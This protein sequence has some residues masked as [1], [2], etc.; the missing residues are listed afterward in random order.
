VVHVLK[1]FDLIF[2]FTPF[3]NLDKVGMLYVVAY[4]TSHDPLAQHNSQFG[5]KQLGNTSLEKR[6][7]VLIWGTMRSCRSPDK[8]IKDVFVS[9]VPS[10]NQEYMYTCKCSLSSSLKHSVSKTRLSH[11]IILLCKLSSMLIH[12]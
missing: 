3:D 12:S 4:A 2:K 1:W 8:A 6:D 10:Y 9:F 7:D 5:D 11:G